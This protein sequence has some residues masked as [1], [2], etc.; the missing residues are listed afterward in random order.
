MHGNGTAEE[1]GAY[2]N[3]LGE[4][5]PDQHSYPTIVIPTT[6]P[7]GF[8]IAGAAHG[9]LQGDALRRMGI[10]TLA[11][12]PDNHASDNSSCDC[13]YCCRRGIWAVD[14]EGTRKL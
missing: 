7:P 2:N 8:A 9:G 13:S 12:I 5:Q 10:A 1:D 6:I 3:E 11:P 14:D 4:E